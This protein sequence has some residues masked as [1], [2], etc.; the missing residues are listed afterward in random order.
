[1]NPEL[2]EVVPLLL[3]AARNL[4]SVSFGQTPVD[5]HELLE[6]AQVLQSTQV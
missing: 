2:H 3:S 1:M 5:D 4:K 6:M